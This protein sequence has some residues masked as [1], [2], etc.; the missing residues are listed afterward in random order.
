MYLNVKLIKHKIKLLSIPVLDLV[1]LLVSTYITGVFPDS[2]SPWNIDLYDPAISAPPCNI[3]VLIIFGWCHS[4]TTSKS[5][6][7]PKLGLSN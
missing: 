2:P 4:I 5:V 7:N 3:V 6:I 1:I